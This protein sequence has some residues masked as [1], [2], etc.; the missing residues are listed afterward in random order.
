[1]A[2]CA[3]K[4][5]CSRNR[6][7]DAND[8]CAGCWREWCRAE[9]SHSPTADR[10]YLGTYGMTNPWTWWIAGRASHLLAEPPSAWMTR[11]V[12][13][14]C[15]DCGELMVRRPGMWKCYRHL[16][17]LMVVERDRFQRSPHLSVVS[18]A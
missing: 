10:S 2:T 17:P 13:P 16:E 3:C 12:A 11:E 8:L 14:R 7:P 15:S 6:M 5:G 9:A 1:M 18:V 4:C